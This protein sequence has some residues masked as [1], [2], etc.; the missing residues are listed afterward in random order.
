MLSALMTDWLTVSFSHLGQ[1]SEREGR[2]PLLA[3]TVASIDSFLA[4][5]GQH[6]RP[7]APA[8]QHAEQR[9]VMDWLQVGRLILG[10]T[11]PPPPL[12]PPPLPPSY[13]PT[14]PPS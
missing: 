9:R 7:A 10:Y 2:E 8:A 3:Q 12:P 6:Q 11:P 5:L 13:P 4:A 1:E 14:P